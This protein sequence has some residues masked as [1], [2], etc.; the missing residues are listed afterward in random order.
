MSL[1]KEDKK[2][3]CYVMNHFG[4][5]MVVIGQK[6]YEIQEYKSPEQKVEE[7]ASAT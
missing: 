1:F 6:L 3:K 2:E 4:K 5:K 7:I